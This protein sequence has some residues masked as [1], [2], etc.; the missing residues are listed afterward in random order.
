MLSI[1]LCLGLPR[2]TKDTGLNNVTIDN[3]NWLYFPHVHSKRKYCDGGKKNQPG[4]FNKCACSQHLRIQ[5][6][7]MR[8]YC[9][10]KVISLMILTDLHVFNHSA[11]EDVYGVPS[12]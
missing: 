12:V 8:R 11:H 9:Y 6:Y 3:T 10:A 2:D 4:D 5:N 1:H 7:P